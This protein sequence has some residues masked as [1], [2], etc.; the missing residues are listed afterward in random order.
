MVRPARP[1]PALSGWLSH[2]TPSVLDDQALQ[3]WEARMPHT[4]SLA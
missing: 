4:L 1:Y 3:L 2:P